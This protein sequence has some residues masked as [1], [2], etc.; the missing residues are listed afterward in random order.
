MKSIFRKYNSFEDFVREFIFVVMADGYASIICHWQD[1]QGILSSLFERT[2]NGES[3]A[4]DIE[5][6][7]CFDDEIS[8]AQMNDDNMMITVFD[9]GAIICTVPIFMKK[10]M[11]DYSGAFY[12]EYDAISAMDYDISGNK[13]PF[14][15]EHK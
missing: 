6:G 13:I 9:T 14:R 8:T 4:L 12:I 2:I 3:F 10:P 1:T 15:I 7:C 5:S 11:Y